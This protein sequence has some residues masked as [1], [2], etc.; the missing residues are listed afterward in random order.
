MSSENTRKPGGSSPITRRCSSVS[1]VTRTS[2]SAM[3]QRW[4]ASPN[5]RRS[6][7]SETSLTAGSSP[8]SAWVGEAATSSKLPARCDTK[9]KPITRSASSWKRCASHPRTRQTRSSGAL[10]WQAE[11]AHLDVEGVRRVGDAPA[12]GAVGLPRPGPHPCYAAALALS[13]LTRVAIFSTRRSASFSCL[14]FSSRSSTASSSPSAFAMR[15]ST[16]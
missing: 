4:L 12:G 3:S 16:S 7:L 11:A 5:G 2:V 9:R 6:E 13:L 1:L 14:R 15:R 10:A 8:A